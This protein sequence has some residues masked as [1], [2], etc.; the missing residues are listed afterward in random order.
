MEAFTAAIVCGMPDWHDACLSKVMAIFPRKQPR[1]SIPVDPE[2]VDRCL[3]GDQRAWETIVRAYAASIFSLS[4]RFTGRREE[5][6]DLTQE[7]F[8][9]IYQRLASFR[10][11]SGSFKS[12]AL[13]VSR[14]LI[15]D[16]YRQERR[17]QQSGGS[18]ELE[19][20]NIP[21]EKLTGPHRSVEQAE[22][23][24]ILHDALRTLSPDIREAI[25]LRDF[26]GM[27]YHEMAQVL[28]VPEGTVK[29]RIS[30]ARMLLA[31]FLS[32]HPAFAAVSGR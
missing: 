26:E 20:M 11:Q 2:L 12:W 24:R 5:A 23:S 15:I 9:R 1:P 13:R 17:F 18:R 4:Y 25:I 14:N 31:K 16:R 29:S 8:I 7:A 22:T 32:H 30:R 10:S 19:S 6:E 21:D 28:G 3:Q 27:N